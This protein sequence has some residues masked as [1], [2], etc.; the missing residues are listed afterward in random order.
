MEIQK[1]ISPLIESQFPSFYKDQGQNFIAFMKSYYEWMEQSGN[2]INMSR[3]VM[4]NTDV[5][6]TLQQFIQYFKNTYIQSL[7]ENVVADKR[8][9][10]KHITE[11]YKSKGTTNAYKLLFRLLFNEDVDVYVPNDYLLRP[12]DATWYVPKYIEVSDSI[13][14][15][16]LV[17]YPIYSSSGATAVVESY[18][19]KIVNL[20]T[21]NILYLSNIDGEFK[22]D[23]KIFSYNFPEISY[24]NAPII[25]GSL[26]TVSITSGG[27]NYNIGDQLSITGSGM[28]GVGTVAGTRSDNG[29][30]TLTLVDGGYGFTLNPE[31]TVSN[32]IDV[33]FNSATGSFSA[34][35]I[36]QSQNTYANATVYFANNNTLQLYDA[37]GNFYVND[38]IIDLSSQIV[39]LGYTNVINLII[40]SNTAAFTVGEYVYQNNGV[41]NTANGTVVTSNSSTVLVTLNSGS[42]S[43]TYQIKGVTSSANANVA[44]VSSGSFSTQNIIQDQNTVAN[45]IATILT[46][47]TSA[48]T[49]T[50]TPLSGTFNVG[51]VIFNS[52]TSINNLLITSNT[53]AFSVGEV[54]FQS[55]GSANTA[56]GKITFA[57]SV[58]IQ[59]SP[60]Y[61]NFSNTYQVK[62]VTSSANAVIGNT[63]SSSTTYAGGLINTY[64]NVSTTA[65][66][67]TLHNGGGVGASFGVGNITDVTVFAINKDV[68]SGVFNERMELE[69]EGFNL[70]I[71]GLP[72]SFTSGETVTASANVIHIDGSYISAGFGGL[73]I[74]N[75]EILSNTSLGIDNITVYTSDSSVS[76]GNVILNVTAAEGDLNNAN[77]VAGTQL[78]SS[79]SGSVINVSVIWPK[80]TVT[81][82]GVVNGFYSNTT[83]VQVTNSLDASIDYL[84]FFV[85]G[86]IITG[87]SSGRTATVNS[88]NRLTGWGSPDYFAADPSGLTN[89]D[90]KLNVA[91]AYDILQV[92]KITYLNKINPGF[93]Y[94][95]DPIV[96]IIEPDIYSIEIPNGKG[97]YWGGDAIVTA[98]AGVSN[99]IVTAVTIN[100]SGYGYLPDETL[101]LVSTTN[102][103]GVSGTA[104]VDL[105]GVNAGYFKNN[106]GFISDIIYIQDSNLYQ[107]FSYQL[108][109]S[110][111]IE[112][113]Q[114][115]VLDL[116]HPA[117]IALFGKY[118]IKSII[119]E[120]GATLPTTIG[121]NSKNVTV[122]Q[123]RTVFNA[124]EILG[125]NSV[126][127]YDTLKYSSNTSPFILGEVVYQS[128]GTANVV[129][130][131]ITGI[132]AQSNSITVSIQNGGFVKTYSVIGATSNTNATLYSIDSL[133][134]SNDILFTDY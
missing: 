85:P 72:I 32:R 123:N 65:I 93:G 62:G 9:L 98:K 4:D 11:L 47:N 51:D 19:Q 115:F 28:G 16:Q 23:N 7:P 49:L 33:T 68:I 39:N 41:A 132:N 100:D 8:L 54:L 76:G 37:T 99:G 31:I 125:F 108:L 77:L 22:F 48:S 46:V 57:N 114:K 5:D 111:A 96:T 60:N 18:F 69:T 134:L 106:R 87:Q 56:N 20:K 12:S 30:V 79:V 97:G 52:Y 67:S 116:V 27:A 102:P 70:N 36:V 80:V 90:T 91:L 1:F 71:S 24:E 124:Q 84:G 2:V 40:S 83:V 117:G 73:G 89:L 64:S 101:N 34:G 14:L 63:Y 92:G 131:N 127:A 88:V 17:G 45:G 35:D 113:Y 21:I 15:N 13:Y 126:I 55:N 43:N 44:F 61:G 107:A 103:T 66:I 26:S 94:S 86:S 121:I 3:S 112:T 10:I 53:A 105:G 118:A 42:F 104:V 74:S 120:S 6:T 109:A 78:I 82:N 25:L 29:K 119:T 133:L 129:V 59:V 38:S 75:G 130:G 110:R 95:L 128:N 122:A 50:A 58:V 81:G